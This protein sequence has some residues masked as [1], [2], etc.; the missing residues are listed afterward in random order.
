[1]EAISNLELWDKVR[2]CPIEAQK[3]IGAG[4]LKGMTDVNPVWRIKTLT[5]QFGP[6][7]QGWY[8]PITEKWIDEGAKGEKVVN[9][10]IDLYVKKDG[11]WSKPIQ[12]IG[13]SR[14]I[15][16]ETAGLHTNDE[17]YKM[18]YTDALSVSCKALGLAADIYWDKDKTKYTKPEK[19]AKPAEAET[20]VS[21][22]ITEDERRELYKQVTAKG[23]DMEWLKTEVDK[24]KLQSTSQLSTEQRDTILKNLDP[25]EVNTQTG[26]YELGNSPV[27][28]NLK[29]E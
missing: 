13:G 6:C 27:L 16:S 8:A 23:K 1:V 7:G 5:E 14:L 10:Q 11:E 3:S 12:G 4:R 24:F 28:D 2:N 17:A 29:T 19:N 25:P 15:E 22:L 18:A 9:V 21:V 26:E 20:K